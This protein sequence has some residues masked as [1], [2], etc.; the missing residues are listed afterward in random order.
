MSIIKR[1]VGK[2]NLWFLALWPIVAIVLSFALR[3][4]FLVSTFWFFGV[5]SIFF[6]LQRPRII[7]KLAAFSL[8]FGGIFGFIVDYIMEVSGG[9]YT[10][11]S[12]FDPFRILGV[13]SID[14]IIWTVLYFFLVVLVYEICLDNEPKHALRSKRF[15]YFFRMALGAL[16]LFFVAFTLYPA[17]LHISYFYFICGIIFCLIP[18]GAVLWKYP[19]L[20]AKF[21]LATTYFAVVALLNEITGLTFG[22]WAFPTFTQHIGSVTIAGVALPLEEFVFWILLGGMATLAWYEYFA[23]DSR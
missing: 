14:F 5:P 3:S 4:S 16:A 1:T 11:H 10:P 18:I 23:D 15:P 8:I 22:H 2:Y 6:S 7:G 13:V 12:S 19:R 20:L 9:W 17:A 21:T